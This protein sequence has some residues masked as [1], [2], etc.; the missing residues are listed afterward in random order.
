[1]KRI[2]ILFLVTFIY[3]A[4]IFSFSVKKMLSNKS[5]RA[6]DNRII[7]SLN[8]TIRR[9]RI[10]ATLYRTRGG[11][12]L[13]FKGKVLFRF[14]SYRLLRR[15]KHNLNKIAGT[16]RYLRRK[17]P[18]IRFQCLGHSDYV[19]RRRQKYLFS[20]RRAAAVANYLIYKGIRR[21]KVSYKGL[22]DRYPIDRRR[23][24]YARA[25]NRR[26]EIIIITKV[27]R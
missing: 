10:N 24:A 15:A 18:F 12:A 8:N 27:R 23:S 9:N 13:R 2:L 14:G 16:L 6:V 3:S 26:V 19:G 25:K 22:S 7:K 20:V 1:M 5:Q 21:N 17:Y 11:V 4:N